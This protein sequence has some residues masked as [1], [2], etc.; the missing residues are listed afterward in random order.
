MKPKLTKSKP[1]ADIFGIEMN[2]IPICIVSV[3]KKKYMSTLF[4]NIIK[5]PYLCLLYF[6]VKISTP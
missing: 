2:K 1:I 4:L 3:E 5:S 6:P